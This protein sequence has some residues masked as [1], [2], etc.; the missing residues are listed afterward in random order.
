MKTVTL[1]VGLTLS[2]TAVA[3]QVRIWPGTAY[4]TCFPS[5][6]PRCQVFNANEQRRAFAERQL[7][8]NQ[9]RLDRAQRDREL[10]LTHPGYADPAWRD[11]EWYDGRR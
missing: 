4:S 9:D 8:E 3:D 6:D 5:T 10:R 2:F 11:R 7:R 1:I